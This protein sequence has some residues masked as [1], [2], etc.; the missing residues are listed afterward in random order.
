M[1]NTSF[2]SIAGSSNAPYIN[3]LWASG[4]PGIEMTNFSDGMVHP[5][6]PNYLCLTGGDNFGIL[7]DGPASSSSYQ[8]A[9]SNPDIASQ[10]EGA[11]PP[12]TWHEYS[13]AQLSACQL[14]DSGSDST[15]PG[16]FASKHD[17][18][19]HFL[20]TQNNTSDCDANDVSYE[21]EGSMPGLAADQNA[22]TFYNYV[23]ISPN[24][25]DDGH[26]SCTTGK[27]PQQ[28][29]WL[30]ANVPIITGSSTYQQN[31][32]LFVTWDE[33][34]SGSDSILTVI[35]SPMLAAPGSSN[36]TAYSHFS[37]LSTI[38]AGF[39]LSSLPVAN[40]HTDPVISD[41]WK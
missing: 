27:V 22:G 5:S 11:S 8:V 10:L 6:L 34:G 15:P 40:N 26:D 41:I 33:G 21:A 32:V 36:N 17:P 38:E 16:T 39:G 2:G 35:L 37:T 3:S 29:A 23:F 7:A 19:T 1:E 30:Q 25:C 4:G 12:L 24:L 31:G 9:A 14:D 18:M 20:I 13:E 28:D